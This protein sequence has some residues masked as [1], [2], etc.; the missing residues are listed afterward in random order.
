MRLCALYLL[1]LISLLFYGADSIGQHD[2]VCT[3][4]FWDTLDFEPPTVLLYD[5]ANDPKETTDIAAHEPERVKKMT[6][7][8]ETWKAS[9]EKSLSGADYPDSPKSN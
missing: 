2:E 5:V 4:V 8:L 7:A 3:P 1:D 6:A 9:V